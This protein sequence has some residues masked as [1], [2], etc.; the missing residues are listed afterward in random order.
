MSMKINETYIIKLPKPNMD[1]IMDVV[2]AKQHVFIRD[3][4]ENEKVEITITKRITMSWIPIHHVQLK[5]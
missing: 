2:L 1:G 5:Y 4:I 3:G